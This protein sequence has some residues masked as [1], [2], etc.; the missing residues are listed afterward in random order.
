MDYNDPTGTSRIVQSLI[1]ALDDAERFHP[2]EAALQTK[3]YLSIIRGHL[4]HAL[5]VADVKEELLATLA[6]VA[7]F[8]YGWGLLDAYMARLQAEVRALL[9]FVLLHG[10]QQPPPQSGPFGVRQLDVTSLR[11]VKNDPGTVLKLRC[12]F[13]K[14]RSLLEVPLLRLGQARSPALPAVSR[15]YSSALLA[16]SRRLLQVTISCHCAC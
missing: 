3:Q 12:L 7:D 8:A 16:F 10:R 13:I 5:R 9:C 15:V 4:A 11:Q 6:A 2:P 14:M 1:I